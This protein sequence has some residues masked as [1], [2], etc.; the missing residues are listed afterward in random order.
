M[1]PKLLLRIVIKDAESCA[2]PYLLRIAFAEA[3]S[4]MQSTLT[5]VLTLLHGAVPAERE[6]GAVFKPVLCRVH[7]LDPCM[8]QPGLL[9]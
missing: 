7:H 9:P 2:G 8:E 1:G 3:L 5:A 6:P 4:D